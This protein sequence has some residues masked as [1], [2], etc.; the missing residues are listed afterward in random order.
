MGID[1][2]R[3]ETDFIRQTVRS[4]VQNPRVGQVVQVYEHLTDDDDSN[5][6][7]DVNFPEEKDLE[8]RVAPI[9]NPGADAIDVPRVGDKVVVQYLHGDKKNAVITDTVDTNKDRAVK[10]LAGMYR[11]KYPS[12]PS[13]AGD[14]NIYL[15]G[16]TYYDDTAGL[17]DYRDLTPEKAFIRIAKKADDM[18]EDALPMTI[19]MVDDPEGDDAYVKIEA[20]K[21]GGADSTVPYGVKINLKDG[22][23]KIV[24]KEG[25]GIESD[26]AGNFT[27]HHESIDFSEG[28]TTSL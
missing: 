20:N 4:M 26:G 19:E 7:A 18:D 8:H 13:P 3:N 1:F 17:N 25:Y 16:A 22:S 21:A 11:R 9:T 12:E 27:W 14:G 23:F 2:E 6:E 5:F 10:G 28:T 15:T 24:D